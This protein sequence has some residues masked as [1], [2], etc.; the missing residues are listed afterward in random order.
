MISVPACSMI[1]VMADSMVVDV[2]MAA[3]IYQDEYE[4][5]V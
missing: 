1:V 3:I 5:Y 2:F 4:V